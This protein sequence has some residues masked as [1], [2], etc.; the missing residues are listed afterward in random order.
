MPP[1]PGGAAT[2]QPNRLGGNPA[3]E[4]NSAPGGAIRVPAA[5]TTMVA[6]PGGG[7]IHAAPDGRKWE[8]DKGGHLSTYSKPGVEAK[9]RPDG[10][11]NSA[12]MIRP[13]HSELNVYRNF[14]GERRV[15]VVRGDRSRIVS[16]GSRHG[17][18][19]RPLASRPG[20]VSRTYVEG[21]RTSVVVYRAYTYRN[22]VYY[23]YVPPVY[24]RPAFYRW[25]RDPWASPVIY[26]WKWSADP[27]YV[28]Y[29]GYFEP[30]PSY[31]TA[32]LWLTDFLL[33]QNLKRAYESR[34]G[35]TD[36]IPP[37]TP[38][39][40][41]PR[42]GGSQDVKL[43]PELKLA[44]AEEVK[45]QLEAANLAAEEKKKDGANSDAGV[46]EKTS[47]LDP[48]QKI[49]VVSMDVEVTT[50]AGT[51]MLTPG[52]IL[53]RKDDVPEDGD[54]LELNVA[55]SKRG[56]CPVGSSAPVEVGSLLEMNNQFSAQ[57]HTG[58]KALAES[59]GRDGIPAGPA[60]DPHPVAEGQA[61]PDLNVESLIRK[62]MEDAK[63][64]EMEIRQAGKD[65]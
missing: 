65:Q 64:A 38:P 27:W 14:H 50:A 63:Q 44:I 8:F 7:T 29:G 31:P 16:N 6:T 53:Q 60:P 42:E 25:A 21:G 10:R 56:D 30:S 24:Y 59:Q 47:P 51:C 3:T 15:E 9:F 43:S 2:V 4:R 57:L 12:R 22:T 13:D 48:K 26:R 20:Y 49:F 39:A 61:M 55:D 45:R 5:R 58:L 11:L 62:Q 37:D 33:A 28:R 36:D 40:L 18:M 52:D 17:Y 19:E 35:E 23:R 41:T 32:A 46:N 54:K 34:Q 1:R